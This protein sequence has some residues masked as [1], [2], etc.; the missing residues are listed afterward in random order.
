MSETAT[1][2]VEVK[3]ERIVIPE[4]MTISEVQEKYSM[5]RATARRAKKNLSG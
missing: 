3:R 1:P 5:N 4:E 2:E